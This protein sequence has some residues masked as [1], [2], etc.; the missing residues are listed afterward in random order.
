MKGKTID[1]FCP[2]CN[3]KTR[4]VEVQTWIKSFAAP[5]ISPAK[6]SDGW[7][8]MGCNSHQSV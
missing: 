6:R 1:K 3:R 8:C 5:N 7:K 2:T 4:W